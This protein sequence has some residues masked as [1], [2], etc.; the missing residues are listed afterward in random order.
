M[1]LPYLARRSKFALSGEER[2][3]DRRGFESQL[4]LVSHTARK[5]K[6]VVKRSRAINFRSVLSPY[7]TCLFR[8]FF[9]LY[10]QMR[11]C[12]IYYRKS[13]WHLLFSSD[14]SLRFPFISPLLMAFLIPLM[15][16]RTC[17]CARLERNLH[18][19]T[20]VT[21]L[22]GPDNSSAFDRHKLPAKMQPTVVSK[23]LTLGTM[24]RCDATL[25]VIHSSRF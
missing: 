22:F 3:L 11:C 23:N 4:L 13:G 6:E 17:S 12:F 24:L 15:P 19:S 7:T 14:E 18:G 1:W 25:L 8:Y 16:M 2:N 21:L 5:V 9:L 10:Q 20:I